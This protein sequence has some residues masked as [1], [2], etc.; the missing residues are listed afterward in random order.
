MTSNHT[1]LYQR[2][3]ATVVILFSSMLFSTSAIAEKGQDHPRLE[4]YPGAVIEHYDYKEYEEGQLILS[5]PYDNGDDWTADKLM[6]LE[7]QVTYIHYELPKSVSTL[8]VFRN[9][10]KTIAKSGGEIL[11]NCERP[12]VTENLGSLKSLVKAR[13]LY[14]NGHEQLQYLAAKVGDSYIS[15]FVNHIYETN[16]FLFIIDKEGLDD[17]KMSPM[18]ASLAKDGKI[19]LYGLYFDSGKETLKPES[20]PELQ[21]LSELMK[22]YPELNILIVGHTDNVG[23]DSLNQNLS[24]GRANSIQHQLSRNYGV[25]P[26]RMNAMGK[27]ESAPVADNST[28]SGRAKNRR[29]EIIAMNPQVLQVA[30]ASPARQ[31]NARKA[32]VKDDNKDDEEGLGMDDVDKLLDVSEKLLD[33]F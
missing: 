17:D 29:V 16:V 14:M 24:N 18:A 3:S 19:D 33:L 21:Q 6:P 4:R 30:M 11:F 28:E 27:G 10:Q 9:Y 12:C 25:K 22:S 2:L 31:P 7:G 23:D 8:Q 20:A 13:D 5:K 1:S 32:E 26:Q 15:L